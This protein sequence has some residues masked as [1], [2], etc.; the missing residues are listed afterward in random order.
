VTLRREVASWLRER[1]YRGQRGAFGLRLDEGFSY[2][3]DVGPLNQR[4]DIH[5]AVGLRSHAV[6]AL[7]TSLLD[8]PESPCRDRCG[9]AGPGPASIA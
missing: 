5:P 3:I 4:T 2:V 8:L 7:M 9:F 1:G 6:E